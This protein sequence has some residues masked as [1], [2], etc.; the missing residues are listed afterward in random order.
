M[1][2]QGSKSVLKAQ[3]PKPQS[4]KPAK[5]LK[6]LHPAT[7]VEDR[8]AM[9]S[10]NAQPVLLAQNPRKAA[11]EKV[12]RRESLVATD[13]SGVKVASDKIQD[14]SR[15]QAQ[16][17][18]VRRVLL[19]LKTDDNVEE[20]KAERQKW[21]RGITDTFDAPYNDK[22]ETKELLGEK[23][24]EFQRWQKEHYGVTVEELNKHIDSG[25]AE[26]S[27]TVLYYM[28]IDAHEKGSLIKS[29]GSAFKHDEKATCKDR[30]EKIIAVLKALTIVRKD[31]VFGDCLTELV[32]NPG[33][34]LKR[35]EENKKENDKKSPIAAARK[36]LENAK[37]EADVEIADKE[38]ENDTKKTNK[39]AKTDQAK[40]AKKATNA[41][42]PGAKS[43]GA[44]V[45]SDERLTCISSEN[46]KTA[47]TGVSSDAD[48]S[49]SFDRNDSISV[50]DA[51]SVDDGE[52]GADQGS[53]EE[54]EESSADE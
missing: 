21:I 12:G 39:K 23:L 30:M 36:A 32:A 2:G 49:V 52:T 48:R 43:N 42:K 8:N 35:K 13:Y 47:G 18:Y 44:A 7:P 20:V 34:V 24:L 11:T 45:D 50:P 3:P 19:V 16:K 53:P 26:A 31:L 40:A 4:R 38:T 46:D 37:K 28:V 14:M 1:S 29:S 5:K 54:E 10:N 25:L 17:V 41:K 9:Q 22:P 27:A 6:A 15:K 51:M 33:Y